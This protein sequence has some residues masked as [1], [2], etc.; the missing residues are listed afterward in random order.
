MLFRS[1]APP[2]SAQ[3]LIYNT[4][5]Y[6]DTVL[7]TDGGNVYG[8]FAARYAGSI[9]NSLAISIVDAGSYSNTWN[10]NGVGVAGLF[11]GSPGTSAQAA[12][13]GSSNDEV[14]IVVMDVGGAFSGKQN[15]VLET[16]GFM[17][18]A[19]DAKDSN[20]NYL[21]YVAANP[22][23]TPL[24]ATW[25]KKTDLPANVIDYYGKLPKPLGGTGSG[26]GRLD[27]QNGD[28]NKIGRAHV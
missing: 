21:T 10:I 23:L 12:S 11:N 24:I 17:S 22:V 19:S 15:T 6:S 14:H 2:S 16:F 7:N 26:A 18:K 4:Q 28:P 3:T 27:L 13:Y 8:P 1:S 20:G 9:G 25:V 5:V